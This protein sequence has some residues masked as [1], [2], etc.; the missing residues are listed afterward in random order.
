MFDVLISCSMYFKNTTTFIELNNSENKS[1]LYYLGRL[2]KYLRGEIIKQYQNQKH[3]WY[4]PWGG[5][6]SCFSPRYD[7]FTTL[8]GLSSRLYLCLLALRPRL[9]VR[10]WVP[11]VKAYA[12][13]PTPNPQRPNLFFFSLQL[14][15]ICLLLCSRLMSSCHLFQAKR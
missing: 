10:S 13:P 7:R 3:F 9:F 5:V 14:S 6:I 4:S 15:H 8:W 2:V 11:T 1:K 12:H